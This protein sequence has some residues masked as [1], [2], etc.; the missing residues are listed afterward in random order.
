MPAIPFTPDQ[1]AAKVHTSL[2]RSLKAMDHARQ[3]AVLWF[4]EMM[5]R[6]LYTELGF[7]SINQYAIKELGFSRTRTGDYVRLARQLD[8][9][10]AVREAMSQGDLGY[11]KAR[12]I[13][14][15]ATRPKPRMNGSKPPGD[16]AGNWFK[17]SRK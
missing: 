8:N 16:R 1:S 17:R 15:V 6:R 7:S 9:L 4:A 5:R 13:I 11:T 10:P 2:R 14:S 12:E 3:C